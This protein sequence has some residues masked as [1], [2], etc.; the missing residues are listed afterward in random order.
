M[1]TTEEDALKTILSVYNGNDELAVEGRFGIFPKYM[2]GILKATFENL[3]H[4][5]LVA[6]YTVCVTGEWYANLTP[7]ALNYF[8]EK[9]KNKVAQPS[10]GQQAYISIRNVN[11]GGGGKMNVGSIDNSTNIILSQDIK[12][13]FENLGKA[14]NDATIDD[15]DKKII[16]EKIIDMKQSLGKPSFSEKYNAF[17]Q[18][19]DNHVTI[20]A[21][22]F[23][24]LSSLLGL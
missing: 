17:V 13:L 12:T 8:T 11:I 18:S 9:E 5:G 16:N 23:P 21:P 22:F 24:L 20:F 6:Q 2:Q 3:K 10:L 19:V 14:L 7:D 15:K 4:E 1:K